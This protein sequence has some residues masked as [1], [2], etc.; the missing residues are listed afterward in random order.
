MDAPDEAEWL[1]A[2]GQGGFASGT[3]STIRTRRY[4]ALLLNAAPGSAQ[5]RVLVNG[6]EAWIDTPTGRFAL[7]GQRYAPDTVWPDGSAHIAG[8]TIDPWPTW[9]FVLPDG[10]AV[11][12]EV[13]VSRASGETVVRWIAGRPARI[14]VRPLLSGR[15]LSRAASREPGVRLHG[16]ARRRPGFVA[17]LPRP[18][19]DYGAG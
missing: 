5:R 16:H 1:E 3:A 15:G 11:T 13:F 7:S 18:A 2:D 17:P 6:I 9:R 4:H 14:T 8:F 19:G 12:Q 10:T